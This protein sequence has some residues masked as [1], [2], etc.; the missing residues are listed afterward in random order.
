V[1]T[2]YV[3]QLG[4][5]GAIADLVAPG[6]LTPNWTIT[7]INVPSQF[8]GHGHGSRLFHQ[9]L[10]D[11]DREQITLQLECYPSGGLDYA[12][13]YNWY[14]RHGFEDGE[15]GYMVRRPRVL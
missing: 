13:L 8:R 11:A 7:R 1:K 6:E 15:W 3:I 9:I 5:F 12:Q 14:S 10:A 4:M 2:C